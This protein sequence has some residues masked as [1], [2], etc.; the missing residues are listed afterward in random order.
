MD[1][2]VCSVLVRWSFPLAVMPAISICVMPDAGA[3][4]RRW[5]TSEMINGSHDQRLSAELG[6]LLAATLDALLHIETFPVAE[7]NGVIDEVKASRLQPVPGDFFHCCGD[8]A[9]RLAGS[10]KSELACVACCSA[11]TLDGIQSRHLP[12]QLDPLDLPPLRVVFLH[13]RRDARVTFQLSLIH[14]SEPTRRTPI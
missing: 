3:R 14:I 7:A 4:T 9:W 12:L 13:R 2:K 1:F 6:T 11:Q 10:G 5:I 8:R